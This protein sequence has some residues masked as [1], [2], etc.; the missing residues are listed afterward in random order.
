MALAI[1]ATLGQVAKAARILIQSPAMWLVLA[2]SYQRTHLVS[3]R[4]DWPQRVVLVRMIAVL[5]IA[6]ALD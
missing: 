1:A 2:G 3:R 5:V 6:N 4:L